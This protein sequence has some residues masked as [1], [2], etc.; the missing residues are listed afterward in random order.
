[1]ELNRQHFRANFFYNFRRGLIQQQCIDKF[2][3][4]F[5]DE[6]PSRTN[7]YRLYQKYDCDASKHVYDIVT[8][9]ESWIY[10]YEPVSI[11]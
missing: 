6:T 5:G 11:Q 4:I 1:M 10:A 3:S 9:D 2:N 8:G 7:V